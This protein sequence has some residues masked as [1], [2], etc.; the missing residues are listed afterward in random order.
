MVPL[1]AAAQST[2]SGS[3]RDTSGAVLP[4]VSVEASSPVLIE[5]VPQR[6]HRRP[7]PLLDRRSPARDLQSRLHAAGIFDAAARRHRTSG[8]FQRL[9]ERRAGGWRVGRNGHRVGRFADRRRPE[10]AEDRELEARGA[11]RVADGAHLC[12][13]RVAG[14][15]RQGR[16]PERRRGAHRRAAAALRARRGRRRQHRFGRWHGDEF[17]LFERRDAA[18]SQR[19]D[20]AGSHGADLVAWAPRSRAEGCSST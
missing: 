4:G 2:I 8:Q 7:G 12:R 6:G 5:Q 20:D 10:L 1:G 14:G 19:L 13:R 3:V 16:G 15:R 11:R 9:G 17:D 18:E